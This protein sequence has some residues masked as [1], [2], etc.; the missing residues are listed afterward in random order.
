[1]EIQ[2]YLI[3]F[4]F[5]LIVGS[6]I[7][8]C[9]LRLP[10]KEDVVKGR[11][12]CFSCGE[13]LRW[14]EMIP[15]ISFLIQR[16]RCRRCKAKLS[17]QYPLVEA[18]CGIAFIWVFY[19]HSWNSSMIF[20][21]TGNLSFATRWL[22]FTIEYE[23]LVNTLVY[24]FT[25]ATLL[26][27]AIIDWR[28]Y[29]IPPGFNYFIAAMGL[30]HLAMHANAEYFEGW[31]TYVIGFFAASAILM[32]IFLVTKGKGIGGGDV[33]LMAAA[34][35]LL[36]WQQ[37]LLALALASILGSIIHL[38]LMKVKGKERLLAFGP[39]L[40]AAIFITILYGRNLIDLYLKLAGG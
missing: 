4:I 22:I 30:V 10:K 13:I 37:I 11:S 34:G 12:H 7:N 18:A 1:M 39:Y 27:L 32:I 28:T 15:L 21:D 8:V 33:K 14:Y 3:V 25:A 16:G 20:Y 31:L 26:G 19:I 36:G 35:L 9:I 5:G 6:F 38:I 2:L 23:W 29:E 40:A 17:W 24:S